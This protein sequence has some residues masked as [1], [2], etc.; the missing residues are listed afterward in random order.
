MLAEVESSLRAKADASDLVQQTLLEAYR[1]FGQFRGRT[2][3]EW[4]AWLRRILARNAAEFVR[5]YRLTGKRQTAREVRSSPAAVPACNRRP[6]T[7]R[8]ARPS[9]AGA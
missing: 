4:L 9:C 6:P 7:R 8:R 5:H 3:A 2:E 1:D